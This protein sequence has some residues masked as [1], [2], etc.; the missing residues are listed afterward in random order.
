MSVRTTKKSKYTFYLDKIDIESINKKYNIELQFKDFVSGS[1][2]KNTTKI[3]DLNM[4]K[5]T[6]DIVSFLDE[7]KRL[8]TCQISMIDFSSQMDVELLKYHCFWCKHPFNT[9]PIGCPI[10]YIPSQAEKKYYSHISRDTYTI[11]EDITANKRQNIDTNDNL[12]ISQGE[13]YQT[14]GVFCSFNCCK[15]WI[16]DNKHDIIYNMSSTLLVKMYNKI[17]NTTLE[18]I[19]PAPHW[20][21]LEQYGGHLNILKFR[22]SFNKIEYEQQ[23]LT[24]NIPKFLSIGILFEEN[25]KF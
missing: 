8:H 13:Y 19:T 17:M 20:R 15:A 11:K 12:R 18:V 21:T 23:G 5:G 16:Q 4:E 22:E 9:K 3:S 24:K 1:E 14:D 7:S 25:Y 10:K 2:S 6:P